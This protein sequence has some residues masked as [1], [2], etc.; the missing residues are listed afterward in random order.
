MI[1]SKIIPE[2]TWLNINIIN[3][4]NLHAWILQMSH[5]NNFP[6]LIFW[7]FPENLCLVLFA[8]PSS[9]QM[10]H[11]NIKYI[12]S[13]W[14]SQVQTCFKTSA[15][16]LSPV[17]EEFTTG[18]NSV[19][20]SRMC[21][22]FRMATAVIGRCIFGQLNKLQKCKTIAKVT[23]IQC[24]N[25]SISQRLLGGR[26]HFNCPVENEQWTW[27]IIIHYNTVRM[28]S[29]SSTVTVNIFDNIYNP[30]IT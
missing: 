17:T 28:T 29:G 1:I 11:A 5:I 21:F 18:H 8:K 14:S 4:K 26:C 20:E 16:F 12:S 3:I 23:S 24:R 27:R 30:Y 22:I 6:H 2:I 25:I 19:T 9:F 10:W 13:W 7:K 15:E